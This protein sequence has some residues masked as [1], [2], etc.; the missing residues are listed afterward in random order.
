MDET[1]YKPMT[2]KLR[3][4]ITESIY[5][6]IKELRT[7]EQNALVNAQLVG[8][9]ALQNIVNALPDGYLVPFKKD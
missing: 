4:E 8:L 3:N 1:I 5:C 9:N 6:N 2:P 7:C